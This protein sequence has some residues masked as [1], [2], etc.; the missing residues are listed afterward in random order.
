MA[1]AAHVASCD[2]LSMPRTIAESDILIDIHRVQSV[3]LKL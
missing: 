1:L 3:A 2:L